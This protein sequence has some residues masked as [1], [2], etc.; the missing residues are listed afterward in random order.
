MGIA[1]DEEPPLEIRSLT[2][3]SGSA[4]GQDVNGIERPHRYTNSRISTGALRA[5]T[6]DA[7]LIV[8]AFAATDRVLA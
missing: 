8:I 7:N 5:W 2:E 1:K 4:G 3:W 6:I